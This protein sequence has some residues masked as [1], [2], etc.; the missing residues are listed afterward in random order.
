M[1][2]LFRSHHSQLGSVFFMVI[3]QIWYH[4]TDSFFKNKAF[5]DIQTNWM[6]YVH[7]SLAL[8]ARGDESYCM[9]NSWVRGI[10]TSSFISAWFSLD[11]FM[12]LS[13]G[14]PI[15][16]LSCHISSRICILPHVPVSVRF[17]LPPLLRRIIPHH[18]PVA[19]SILFTFP[20]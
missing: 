20:P 18:D 19:E 15:P 17:A 9:Q 14:Q 3:S 5:S 7:A 11:T 6:A 10:R 13:L 12:S 1:R 2:L 16:C 4:L 8:L